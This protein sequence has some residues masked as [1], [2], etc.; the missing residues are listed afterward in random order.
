MNWKQFIPSKSTC[1]SLLATAV[2]CATYIVLRPTQV[3]PE[4]KAQAISILGG[5]IA[6]IWGLY[7]HGMASK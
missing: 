6:A 5:T 7:S 4:Q 3:T 2:A 1:A